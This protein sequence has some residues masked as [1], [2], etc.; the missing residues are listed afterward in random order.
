MPFNRRKRTRGVRKNKV[1]KPP[2]KRTASTSFK[3][4][5]ATGVR[6]L[7]SFIPGQPIVRPAVDFLLKTFGFVKFSLRTDGVLDGALTLTGASSSI[8]FYT[9]DFFSS[10]DVYGNPIL[11]AVKP[12]ALAGSPQDVA[13]MGTVINHKSVRLLQV[14][15]K[16]QPTGE[17]GKRAGMWAMAWQPNYTG[18]EDSAYD[19]NSLNNRPPTFE[20]V[21]EMTY[22]T[23][24]S[25]TRGLVLTWRPKLQRDGHSALP[26]GMPG[27]GVIPA[28]GWLFV[29]YEDKIRPTGAK[30]DINELSA[31]VNVRSRGAFSIKEMNSMVAVG[32]QTLYPTL[33]EGKELSIMCHDGV[34]SIHLPGIYTKDKVHVEVHPTHPEYEKIATRLALRDLTEMAL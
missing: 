25:A 1:P 2:K 20:N 6:T 8:P 14:T 17:Q 12:V 28:A 19:L 18:T 22:S 26:R 9:G 16:L 23:W 5:I 32:G 11:G 3:Q 13:V 15:W 31:E 27:F 24:G 34:S 33:Y 21:K 7:S 4:I 29:A 10:I 30:F